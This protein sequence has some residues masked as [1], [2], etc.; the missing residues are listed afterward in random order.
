MH[1]AESIYGRNQLSIEVSCAICI[2]EKISVLVP[3]IFNI[4]A[5][6]LV[7]YTLQQTLLSHIKLYKESCCTAKE[8][9]RY[10]LCL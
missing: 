1:K 10:N 4:H 2:I 3:S 9:L 7:S 5:T 6:S 8:H